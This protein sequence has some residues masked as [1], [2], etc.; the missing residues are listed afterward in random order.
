MDNEKKV[1]IS[2]DEYNSLIKRNK[3][4]LE[5]IHHK[6]MEEP[7]EITI[8]LSDIN[9]KMAEIKKLFGAKESDKVVIKVD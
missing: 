9:S 2:L 7:K 3:D 1:I 6:E 4:L 5:A 8:T